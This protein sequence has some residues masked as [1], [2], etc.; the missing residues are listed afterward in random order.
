MGGREELG[1]SQYRN[2]RVD[3]QLEIV[4]KHAT[5]QQTD[6]YARS[7]L[8]GRAVDTQV[9]NHFGWCKSCRTRLEAILVLIEALRMMDKDSSGLG[10][11]MTRRKCRKAA[12]AT[13]SA[14]L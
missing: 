13:R 8:G 7:L 4:M 2:N 6:D 12:R 10:S 9:E 11:V 3:K 5:E 1:L 14:G